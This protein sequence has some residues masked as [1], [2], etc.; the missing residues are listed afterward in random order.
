MDVRLGPSMSAI[1]ASKGSA[2]DSPFHIANIFPARGRSALPPQLSPSL[3]EVPGRFFAAIGADRGSSECPG[4]PARGTNCLVFRRQSTTGGSQNSHWVRVRRIQNTATAT[5]PLPKGKCERNGS[6]PCRE[7]KSRRSRRIA[8]SVQCPFEAEVLIRGSIALAT[9]EIVALHP[10][11]TSTPAPR[12]APRRPQDRVL[13]LS[14]QPVETSP[15]HERRVLVVIQR[16]QL[17]DAVSAVPAQ[18]R[19]KCE[20]HL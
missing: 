10:T 2:W 20:A 11:K 14:S 13:T 6:A 15:I 5:A 1:Q 17:D 7:A 3:P 4:P 12:E 8:A 9:N 16:N 19:S 18:S